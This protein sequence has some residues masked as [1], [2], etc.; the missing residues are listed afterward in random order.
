MYIPVILALIFLQMGPTIRR[1]IL[2][3]QQKSRRN[4][5]EIV[6]KVNSTNSDNFS[7]K[8]FDNYTYLS[9]ISLLLL[10]GNFCYVVKF[11]VTY[12]FLLLL[13]FQCMNQVYITN[14]F[15]CN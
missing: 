5:F 4:I 8:R 1:S 7:L 15:K 11:T 12:L 3:T 2:E 13:I 10:T 6:Q 9:V 14:E